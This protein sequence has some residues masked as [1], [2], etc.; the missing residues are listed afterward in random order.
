[1]E[2]LYRKVVKGKFPRI[3][4]KY[5]DELQQLLNKMIKLSPK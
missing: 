1:M 3:P 2:E 4:N 5:S